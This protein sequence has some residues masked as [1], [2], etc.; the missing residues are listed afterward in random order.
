MRVRLIEGNHVLDELGTSLDELHAATAT[1]V[2]AQRPW[3]EA[4]VR[5]YRDHKPMAVVVEGADG[6]LEAAALLARR[7]RLGV[8]EV[9]A[10]GHGPSDQIR[11]PA[12]D[13]AAAEKLSCGMVNVLQALPGWWRL[14]LK[15]LPADDV[16][17]NVLAAQLSCAQLVTGD[18]SPTT[19]FGA[20]RSLRT[21]VSRNHHQQVRRMHNR[22]RRD[23]LT[24]DV[25]HLQDAPEIAAVLPE[26]EDVCRRRDAQLHRPSPLDDKRAGPFFRQ[27]IME[28]AERGKVELTL[29]RLGGELAAYVLCFLDGHVYRMWS[30]RGAPAWAE[31]SA[32]RLANNAALA[33]ALSNEGCTEFDWM[34]GDEDYKLSMANHV[35]QAQ[36]LLAW[37]SPAVRAVMDAP[38]RLEIELK[39]AAA[40]YERVERVVLAI[41][42]LRAT[43]ATIR[44]RSTVLSSRVP[45]SSPVRDSPLVQRSSSCD[46]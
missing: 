18:A 13:R 40:R 31:Y 35:E 42:R 6:R 33:N 22:I 23:G 1:P 26:V 4:W 44:R 15:H 8:T 30:C 7:S 11:L 38:R 36:D 27:V 29:L 5:C 17:A 37:S 12:R 19:R 16:V 45:L 20:D 24:L 2:T 46:R 32:G 34:R 3:L 41:K 21:Y 14:V 9:F 43:A 25:V 39:G 10:M 28:H